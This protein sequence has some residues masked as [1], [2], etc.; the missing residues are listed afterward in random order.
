ME[1]IC[2]AMFLSYTMTQSLAIF[3]MMNEKNVS[4][5]VIDYCDESIVIPRSQPL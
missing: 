1:M 4:F 3:L 2:N 5:V